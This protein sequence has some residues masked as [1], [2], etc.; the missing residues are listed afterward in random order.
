MN[1]LFSSLLMSCSLLLTNLPTHATTL[2]IATVAPGGTSWMKTFKAA[3]REIRDLTE[4]RVKLKFF[5]GGVMGNDQS[6]MRKMRV[7]QLHGGAVSGSALMP[8][9]NGVQIYSL[10]FLF[11]DHTE[12]KHAR[13]ILDPV[14]KRE[15]EKKGLVVLGISEGGFAHLFSNKPVRK[16]ADL[17]ARKIWVPQNDELALNAMQ[18]AQVNPVQLPISDVYTGLQTGLIDT[19]SIN[20]AGAIALQWHAKIKHMADKPLLFIMG[21]LVVD[22]RAFNQLSDD[23]QLTVQRVVANAF[24]QFDAQ[25]VIDDENAKRALVQNGVDVVP[26]DAVAY[27]EWQTLADSSIAQLT[28]ANPGTGALLQEVQRDLR[29]RRKVQ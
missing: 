28:Q 9:Y 20:P 22:K 12:V 14:V 3:S 4:G 7:G 1:K 6:V 27:L 13:Q 2:K 24:E 17:R 16:L 21:F 29:N 18:Q 19:V 15:L 11:R 25:N 5:P 10:P 23:D 26:I 8:H